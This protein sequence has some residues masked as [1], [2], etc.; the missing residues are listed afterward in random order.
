[1]IR[2]ER[3]ILRTVRQ[4]DLDELYELYSNI[5]DRGE[6]YP[7]TMRSEPG[8][9][10]RFAETGFWEEEYGQLL[11]T[12]KENRLLGSVAFFKSSTWRDTLEIGFVIFKPEDWGKGFMAEAVS[13]FVSYLFELKNVN[14]IEANV[15]KGNEGSQKVLEKC[16]FSFEGVLRQTAFFRGEFH[17]FS[18]FSILRGESNP[19]TLR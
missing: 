3:L 10:K 19:L 15:I 12:D 4:T 9:K 13:L 8:Y 18:M 14:R 11:I 16:G 1:M 6:F 17:D 2:S 5:K 7:I